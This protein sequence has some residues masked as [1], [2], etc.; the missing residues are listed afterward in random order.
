[1]PEET[2]G[3]K[4][5]QGGPK[6]TG[7]KAN[8]K[9]DAKKSNERASG[10]RRRDQPTL[11]ISPTDP[12]TH[13]EVIID[14]LNGEPDADFM[15]RVDGPV[16]QPY[17]ARLKTDPQGHAQLIWRTPQAGEYSVNVPT[18]GKQSGWEETF[19]VAEQRGMAALGR[20]TDEP[21]ASEDE[22]QGSVPSVEPPSVQEPENP[23]TLSQESRVARGDE[24]P[25][26]LGEPDPQFFDAAGKTEESVENATVNPAD[27][28]QQAPPEEELKK[29][30]R[31]AD[32]A[33]DEEDN[34][35]VDELKDELRK[36]DLPVSGN[37][38]EL[39]ARLKEDK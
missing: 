2:Q 12:L 19:S 13:H 35:T 9:A 27:V 8:A 10:P 33:E 23:D 29:V 36:R 22:Q 38:D 28:A 24:D 39:I 20:A 37:R 14:F 4:R 26:V 21:D 3:R 17:F 7:A 11:R 18:V 30:P 31:V 1:M 34:R 6:K 15:V 5:A 32:P 25:E 16:A